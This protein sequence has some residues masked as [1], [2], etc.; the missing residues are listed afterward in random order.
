MILQKLAENVKGNFLCGQCKKLL[1]T[2]WN[3]RFKILEKNS[4]AKNNPAKKICR[5]KNF[6]L[7]IFIFFISGAITSSNILSGIVATF[8]VLFLCH[9]QSSF[10]N[11]ENRLFLMNLHISL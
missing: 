7:K 1:R 8:F 3:F 4:R 11:I 9:W 5:Q 10:M 2:T 6:Y